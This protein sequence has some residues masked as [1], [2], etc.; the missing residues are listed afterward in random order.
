MILCLSSLYSWNS[1]KWPCIKLGEGYL[2]AA[3]PCLNTTRY[4]SVHWHNHSWPDVS[5]P[6]TAWGSSAPASALTKYIWSWILLSNLNIGSNRLDHNHVP[7]FAVSEPNTAIDNIS[8]GLCCCPESSHPFFPRNFFRHWFWGY[9]ASFWTNST[10]YASR[11]LLVGRFPFSISANRPQ[12]NAVYAR[13]W[14]G[15]N[16]GLQ[17]PARCRI[18]CACSVGPLFPPS[19]ARGTEAWRPRSRAS[20]LAG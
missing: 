13:V 12:A 18:A 17:L 2:P 4:S 14:T 1:W 10:D 15:D 7:V 11:H 3:M 6:K 16:K 20:A 9:L 8:V 19:Q 5:D